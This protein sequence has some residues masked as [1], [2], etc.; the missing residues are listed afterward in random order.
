MRRI[1]IAIPT[2][3]GEIGAATLVALVRAAE[4][5]RREGWGLDVN[6]RPYDSILPRARNVLLTQFWDGGFDDLLLWDDD[7][8]CAPGDFTRLMRHE[9]EMVGGLYRSREDP[10]RYIFNGLPGVGEDHSLGLTEIESLGTGFLRLTRACV[11]RMVEAYPDDI[12]EDPAIGRILWPFDFERIGRQYFGEDIRF[13]RRYRAAGGRVW[14]DC[15]LTLHHTGP[16]RFSGHYGLWRARRAP[17]AQA[18]EADLAAA[19]SGLDAV[20][21]TFFT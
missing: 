7:I 8:A 21:A 12:V 20:F 1:Q 16:K 11:A 2:Y 14:A 13:C 3:S 18:D 10:E 4:E 6:V 9:V 15:E 17:P 5:A 19:Q